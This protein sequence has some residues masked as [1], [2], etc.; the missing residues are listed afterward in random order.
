M[1]YH[2]LDKL[3]NLHDGYRRGFRIGRHVVLVFQ[4]E[5]QVY[6][7]ENT[8]PHQGHPLHTATI[9]G[10]IIRCASHGFE[11]SLSTGRNVNFGGTCP[12]LVRY[13]PVYLGADL[14]VDL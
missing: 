2:R 1:A 3:V 4:V 6:L 7:V 14:G 10:D 12:D 9:E 11:F 8:C 13:D 5:G